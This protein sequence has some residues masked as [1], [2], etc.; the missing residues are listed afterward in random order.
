MTNS[1]KVGRNE[2]CPCGGGKKF[3]RCHGAIVN[4][5]PLPPEAVAAYQRVR[6]QQVQ[7]ERQQGFGHPIISVEHKGSRLVA[8]KNR[9]FHS[10][11]HKTFHDFL[12][13]YLR[14]VFGSVFGEAELKKPDGECHP[15]I[16][17]YRHLCAEQKRNI[18]NPGKV[19][20]SKMTNGVSAYMH[21]AYDLYSLE[22]N[23]ELRSVLLARLRRPEH[24]LATCYEAFVAAAFVRAGFE[25]KFENEDD[26]SQTHVEFTATSKST[27]KSF[28]VE[29]KNREGKLKLGRR[30]QRALKKDA[31]HTR[32]V[33]INLNLT[34]TGQGF[35]NVL[36]RM[37]EDLREFETVVHE[38]VPLPPAYIVLTN[39]LLDQRLEDPVTRGC[40]IADGF[41]I[42]DFRHDAVFNS[43]H[44]A[45]ESRDRHREMFLLLESMKQ[46]SE[47]PATFDGEIPEYA[48]GEN[49]PERLLIGNRYT[50]SLEGGQ[51][52]TGVL[53]AATIDEEKRVAHCALFTDSREAYVCPR[54]LTDLEMRA[55]R[56]HPDTFFGVVS[57]NGRNITSPFELF[58]FILNSYK[59]TARDRLLEFLSDSKDIEYLR[60]LDQKALAK[61][62]AER[63]TESVLAKSAKAA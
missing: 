33:F 21:L 14:T 31:A 53:T 7:T 3:K 59:D 18:V 41:K 25:I 5:Q 36:T 55:W 17:W 13:D 57:Q 51:L 28:S 8:V 22:H 32:V 43:F 2:P 34:D 16:T 46:H 52:V 27:G 48:F 29:A 63:C 58:D 12:G 20:L 37:V 19:H 45:L 10:K 47:V 50:M 38:G 56:S 42:P 30:L 49:V 40:A 39:K 1:K 62:Y 60:T 4:M 11:T 35:E 9:I 54:V 15:V 6:A 23:T 26:R 44:D 61:V 24:F